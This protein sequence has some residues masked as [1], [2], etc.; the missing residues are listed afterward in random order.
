MGALAQSIGQGNLCRTSKVWDVVTLPNQHRAPL[1]RDERMAQTFE[2]TPGRLLDLAQATGNRALVA[3]AR[4]MLEKRVRR[5]GN[6][7]RHSSQYR[8]G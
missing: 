4:C 8:T 2:T 7:D 1:T 5:C 3:L 6:E